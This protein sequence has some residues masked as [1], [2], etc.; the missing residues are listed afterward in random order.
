MLP[1]QISPSTVAIKLNTKQL[2]ELYHAQEC[3]REKWGILG[4][5][6]VL[7]D[8]TKEVG[9]LILPEVH[10][11]ISAS[12]TIVHGYRTIASGTNWKDVL[13]KAGI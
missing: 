12:Y 1:C 2:A 10:E 7:Q 11:Q 9:T 4:M 13:T 5:A 3:C 8:G 6:R